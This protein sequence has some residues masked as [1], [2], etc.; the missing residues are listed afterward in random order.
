[1][2]LGDLAG[3]RAAFGRALEIFVTVYGP[4]APETRELRELISQLA[5]GKLLAVPPTWN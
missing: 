2:A 3:G 5:A 1:M 4:E